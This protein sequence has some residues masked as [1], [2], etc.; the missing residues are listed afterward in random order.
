MSLGGL[1]NEA[2]V[3]G[4]QPPSRADLRSLSQPENAPV[5]TTVT[6]AAIRAALL[7]VPGRRHGSG[8][9]GVS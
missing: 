9:E 1:P 4:I 8:A 5:A 7:R 6:G 3:N 2:R